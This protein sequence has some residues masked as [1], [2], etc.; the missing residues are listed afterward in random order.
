M[1]EYLVGKQSGHTDSSI[2]VT[3][4]LLQQNML[5]PSTVISL[6]KNSMETNVHKLNLFISLAE[7]LT[8]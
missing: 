1:D 7:S 3:H 5:K 4:V 2:S 6:L 8:I